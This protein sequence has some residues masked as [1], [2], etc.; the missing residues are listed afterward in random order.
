MDGKFLPDKEFLKKPP[1]ATMF[2][3]V[4]FSEME[5]F[6]KVKSLTEREFSYVQLES[7][8][9]PKWTVELSEKLKT[10]VGEGTKILAL[11]RKIHREELPEIKKKCIK[12]RNSLLKKDST[13]RIIPGYVTSHNVIIGSIN[14][15]FHR[16]YLFHG[17]YAEVVYKF[18]KLQMKFMPSAPEFFA[19]KDV[20][21][22][23]SSLREYH[24]NRDG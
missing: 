13:L 9:L 18:E 4:S 20:N 2:I 12:I 1:G 3:I 23:F 11:K 16:V 6:Y 24:I 15:D 5:A 14:D 8:P 21:Y 22:F 17:V 7:I 10:R 19:L